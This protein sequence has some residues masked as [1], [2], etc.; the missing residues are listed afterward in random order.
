MFISPGIQHSGYSAE[1]LSVLENLAV[2]A[3][4]KPYSLSW[5]VLGFYFLKFSQEVRNPFEMCN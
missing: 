1:Q 5:K 3:G 4:A 2:V